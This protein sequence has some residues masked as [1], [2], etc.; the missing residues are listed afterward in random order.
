MAFSKVENAKDYLQNE[1]LTNRRIRMESANRLEN[2]KAHK[3]IIKEPRQR[4]K[5]H[6]EKDNLKQDFTRKRTVTE[7]IQPLMNRTMEDIN[8]APPQR[9][10]TISSSCMEAESSCQVLSLSP[11]PSSVSE[12]RVVLLGRTGAGKKAAGNTILGRDECGAQDSPAEVTQSGRREGDVCGRRLVLVDTPDWFCPD[13]SLEERRKDV[14]RCIHLSAPGPHAFLLVVPVEPAEGEERRAVEV[15]DEMFGE[16]C[17]GHTII[18]FTHAGSLGEQ[19]MDARSQNMQMLIEKCMNSYCV[20]NIEDKT[21]GA[22]VSKLLNQIEEI[23]AGNRASFYSSQTYQEAQA[24]WMA[25][26]NV[27][28]ERE[29]RMQRRAKEKKDIHEMCV[30]L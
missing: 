6:E 12:L 3:L 19:K 13:V 2:K 8:L 28:R 21:R 14:G 24:K 23:M 1:T 29:E 15:M 7:P 16:E 22:Q 5:L 18:L 26:E 25:M 17:W 11:V 27:R 20:L 10:I 30:M 9:R 4:V